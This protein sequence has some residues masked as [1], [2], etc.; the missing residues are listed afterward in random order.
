[1]VIKGKSVAGAKRLALHLGRKDTNE[2]RN[3]TIELRDVAAPELAGALREMEAVAKGCPNCKK[4]FYHASINTPSNERLSSEQR[5]QAIDRLEKELGLGGQPRVVV[6]HEKKDGREHCHVVWS[7][8][9]L[10][11]MRTIHDGHNFRKHELVARDLEREFGHE[12]VQGAHIERDG[13]PRPPRTPSHK[14]HQQGERTG[15]K[16]KEAR[17]HLTLLWRTTG[18]GHTLADALQKSGWI[19]ARGDRRDF[20]AL[21]PQGGTHSLARRIEGAKAADVRARFADLDPRRL[22]SVA[23]ARETQRARQEQRQRQTE[24]AKAPPTPVPSARLRPLLRQGFGGQEGYGGQAGTRRARA[25]S[26][27]GKD[28]RR[29]GARRRE[30]RRCVVPAFDGRERRAVAGTGGTREAA[31]APAAGERAG[32]GTSAPAAT[33]RTAA[34]AAGA[35]P[36]RASAARA[37]GG[38]ALQTPTG[39]DARVWARGE[40]GE[41]TRRRDRTR[42]AAARAR[43]RTLG[44]PQRGILRSARGDSPAFSTGLA[45]VGRRGGREFAE[46]ARLTGARPRAPPIAAGRVALAQ[47]YRRAGRALTGI[48]PRAGWPEQMQ[49]ELLA[50]R[51]PADRRAWAERWALHLAS[52]VVSEAAPARLASGARGSGLQPL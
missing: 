3:E 45:V 20:V 18:S 1:M 31:R 16:P 35:S 39:I 46:A 32:G 19:L 41:R 33:T 7:R 30:H 38:G 44:R 23:E 47:R 40:A 27:E 10:D 36:A 42:A 13:Q 5:L 34:R 22:P 52:R 25:R 43:A 28:G 21:D 48:Q 4:P 9:R 50:C 51:T 29:R 37:R 49:R 17:E 26:A 11:D 15:I 24:R 2:R 14:E 6:V 8:I 12:R